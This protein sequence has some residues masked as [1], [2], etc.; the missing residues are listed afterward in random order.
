MKAERR[1]TIDLSERQLI[2]NKSEY[3]SIYEFRP[4]KSPY[5]SVNLVAC[6]G[7]TAVTGDCG[8]WIFANEFHPKKDGYVDDAYWIQK[9]RKN[10]CQEPTV[11]DSS[12]CEQQIKEILDAQEDVL[13]VDDM[14]FLY[15]L[16][17]SL[18]NEQAYNNFIF[19]NKDDMWS[20]TYADLPSGRKIRQ[21]LL[22]LFDMFDE[23]CERIAALNEL[24]DEF[25]ENPDHEPSA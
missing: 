18:I 8:N 23:M 5:S 7:I 1:T 11:F 13:T 3:V 21:H 22:I 6:L 9:L 14:Q 12:F 20:G 16:Q 24:Y 19:W 4:P 25:K 10:S 17:G 2:V 15:G